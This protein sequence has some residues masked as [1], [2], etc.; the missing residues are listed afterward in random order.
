MSGINEVNLSELAK[1][2]LVICGKYCD[3]NGYP[4]EQQQVTVRPGVVTKRYVE[5]NGEY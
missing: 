1:L 3:I 5:I 4:E 2:E